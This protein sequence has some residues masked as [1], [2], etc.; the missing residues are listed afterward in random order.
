MRNVDVKNGYSIS[1]PP[2]D[3]GDCPNTYSISNPSVDYAVS[4]Q[5]TNANLIFQ[6]CS[7]YD[8]LL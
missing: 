6:L 2:R 5:G 4:N 3:S 7:S 8:S 1:C